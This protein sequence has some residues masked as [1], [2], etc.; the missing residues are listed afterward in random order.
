MTISDPI[1][2]MLTRIRNAQMKQHPTVSIPSSKFKKYLLDAM[3][4]EGFISS[5][6]VTKNENG[7]F[8]SLKVNLKYVH[9][10]PVIREIKRISKP[11][12]RIY[13]RFE[14]LPRVLNGL[15]ISIIS[16]SK[17][18]LSD[19]EARDQKLGGEIICNIS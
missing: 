11:G 4:R 16:T 13:S 2:D 14:S 6:E 12:R 1:G 19:N 7:T 5:Y 8:E 18:I 3:Q 10:N 9:G 15:G 17:G